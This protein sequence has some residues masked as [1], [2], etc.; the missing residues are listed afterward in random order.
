M[1]SDRLARHAA[2][3]A[4]VGEAAKAIGL[5]QAMY[6]V[7][8]LALALAAVLLGAAKAMREKSA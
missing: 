7:P 2:G 8:V 4:A 6:V 5:H 1:L 3:A